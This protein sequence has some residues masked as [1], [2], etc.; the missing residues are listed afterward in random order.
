MY[1]NIVID[2]LLNTCVCVVFCFGVRICTICVR[3]RTQE[4]KAYLVFI[5]LS[6]RF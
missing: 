6:I 4:T 1:A 5:C 3:I 2:L